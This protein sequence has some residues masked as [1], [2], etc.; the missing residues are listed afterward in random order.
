MFTVQP[1]FAAAAEGRFLRPMTWSSAWSGRALR[2]IRASFRPNGKAPC[3][4]R[5]FVDRLL[6]F[7]L[8]YLG[9]VAKTL[10][11]ATAEALVV[12]HLLA[13][14]QPRRAAGGHCR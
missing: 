12:A 5:C 4:P 9:T 14:E 11:P 6:H 10:Q 2:L 3:I 8:G 1:L 13:G 7:A